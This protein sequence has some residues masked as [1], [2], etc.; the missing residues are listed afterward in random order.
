MMMLLG[1]LA[2]V[3]IVVI[4][5]VAS[6]TIGIILDDFFDNSDP[7]ITPILV[8]GT[9]FVSLIFIAIP[10]GEK[11]SKSANKPSVEICYLNAVESE[12][13]QEFEKQ[14]KEELSLFRELYIDKCTKI[15]KE[16]RDKAYQYVLQ[17]LMKQAN[18]IN[19]MRN[20]VINIT[21]LNASKETDN[22]K[23]FAKEASKYTDISFEGD[24]LKLK[25]KE[26]EASPLCTCG[27]CGRE[28]IHEMSIH[29]NR[30]ECPEGRK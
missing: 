18:D 27:H 14:N 25:F 19:S 15:S 23:T 17:R 16:Q 4:S 9:L 2:A 20:D 26:L 21:D 30:Q 8:I 11:I 7:V 5:I 10:I 3:G 1:I 24:I 6:F 29:L 13:L 22:Y 12:A 28:V